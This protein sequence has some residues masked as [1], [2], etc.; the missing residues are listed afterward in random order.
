M[1]NTLDEKI[2]ALK[3]RP[4][5]IVAN[6]AFLPNEML[7]ECIK[8]KTVMALDGAASRLLKR[9]MMPSFILGDFDS[10]SI[11]DQRLWGIKC[12]ADAQAESVLPYLGR[13]DVVM[14]PQKNQDLTDLAKAVRYCDACGVNAIEIVCATGWRMDHTLANLRLL[15]SAYRPSRSLT[16]QTEKET[17]FYVKDDAVLVRGEPGDYCGVLS[18]PKATFFSKGLKYNG[19]ASVLE[20]GSWDSTSNQLTTSEAKIEVEGEALIVAP[21]QLESHKKFKTL[22]YEAIARIV[23]DESEP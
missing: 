5:V 16:L 7:S 10:L 2:A 13:D 1:S 22:S 17:L 9:G 20:F 15:K 23:L 18:F 19:E 6:A 12:N 11:T 4:C 3:G 14:L 21:G 8:D